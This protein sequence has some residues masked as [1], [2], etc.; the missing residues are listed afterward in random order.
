ALP[1][2]GSDLSLEAYTRQAAL[3]RGIDPDI[4][5]RVAMSEGGLDDPVRQ[6]DVVYQG[7]REQSYGPFQLNV[8]GGLGSAAL[9]RGIDPRNPAHVYRA[10]D[11]ALE[12]AAR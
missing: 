11:F 1:T 3:A 8:N 2:G 12:D 6:S 9:Q 7:Q 4:A 10:I 5:V